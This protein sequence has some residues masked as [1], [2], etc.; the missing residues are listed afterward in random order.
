MSLLRPLSAG[1]AQAAFINPWY[2]IDPGLRQYLALL[3]ALAGLSLLLV[4]WAFLVH[5]RGLRR[6]R[7]SSSSGSRSG[8]RR[9]SHAA[10]S[11]ERPRQRKSR[12]RSREPQPRN[13]TLAETGGLPGLGADEPPETAC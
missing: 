13:P 2:W 9:R 8:R 12:R 11:G 10:N 1:G 6:S 4:L 7:R 3:G 5:K